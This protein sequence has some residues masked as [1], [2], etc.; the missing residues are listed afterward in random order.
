MSHPE[1]RVQYNAINA[2][3]AAGQEILIKSTQP[4]AHDGHGTYSVV[5]ISSCPE[6]APF[7]QRS[8]RKSVDSYP[9]T[10]KQD[11]FNIDIGAV[12]RLPT[13]RQFVGWLCRLGGMRLR[14]GCVGGV[15]G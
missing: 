11:D 12:R 5:L 4:V 10:V 1:I 13:T 2:V 6:G 3:I 8:L 14:A 9:E 7:S 15:L